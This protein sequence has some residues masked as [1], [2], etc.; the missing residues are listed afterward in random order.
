M[1]K[2]SVVTLSIYCLHTKRF[3][4]GQRSRSEGSEENDDARQTLGV[5]A[6]LQQI[7]RGPTLPSHFHKSQVSSLSVFRETE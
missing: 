1:N 4:R 5:R 3:K 2:H 6:H 7:S